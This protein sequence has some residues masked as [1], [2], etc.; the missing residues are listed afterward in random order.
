MAY[1]QRKTT[2]DPKR[3][4]VIIVQNAASAAATLVAGRADLSL[5]D[6]A[7]THRTVFESSMAIINSNTSSASADVV[8]EEFETAPTPRPRRTSSGT[9]DPLSMEL[10]FGKHRGQTIGSVLEQGDDGVSY[11]EWVAE[12]SNNDVVRVAAKQALASV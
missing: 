7:N 4:L 3:Q 9:Q 1:P 12:N 5:T 10:S 11:I 2:E 8:A 6:F